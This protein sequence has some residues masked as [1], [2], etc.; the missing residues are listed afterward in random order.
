MKLKKYI[1]TS[2]IV[3]FVVFLSVC[4]LLPLGD[5]ITHRI[6][7]RICYSKIA[8]RINAGNTYQELFDYLESSIDIGMPKEE[9]ESQ[10]KRLGDIKERDVSIPGIADDSVEY[11][12]DECFVG[13]DNI[14]IYIEYRD[15]LVESFHMTIPYYEDW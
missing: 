2:M 4:C 9:I 5:D 12:V 13:G 1:K 14:L 15:G 3:L 8:S 10:L 6:D 7:G 11:E